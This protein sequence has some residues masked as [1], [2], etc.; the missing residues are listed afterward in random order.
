MCLRMLSSK[1]NHLYWDPF[2]F[3]AD[4]YG[5]PSTSSPYDSKSALL[6]PGVCAL[7]LAFLPHPPSGQHHPLS[8][9]S[10]W[11][12]QYLCNKKLSLTPSSNLLNGWSP[13]VL[14]FP[15]RMVVCD[16][17]PSSGCSEKASSAYLPMSV[18]CNTCYHSVMFSNLS[19]DPDPQAV[20]QT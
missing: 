14:N 18:V 19:S 3:R 9:V 10:A 16:T 5:I 12:I 6:K 4:S 15:M 8:I 13:D 17:E 7:L 11:P 2:P 20:S 1:A